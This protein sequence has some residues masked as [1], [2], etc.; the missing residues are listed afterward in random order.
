MSYAYLFKYIIIG[1]T[2]VGKS[3]LL[4]QFT[5]KRFQQVHDL[6]IGV[7][8][9]ARMITIDG[10]QIKLQIWD[11][12]GQESFRSITRSYYRGA[13]GALLVYDITRRDT[14][15]HLTSWL[16]DA[17]QHANSNMT[18]ML[19]GNKCD[20]EQRRAV[21]FEEGQQFANEHGL[22][23]LETSAKTAANVEEAFINTARKIYEKIQQGVFDVSNESYG[24]KV[25]MAAQ[26]TGGVNL[27]APAGGKQSSG[28][29]C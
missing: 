8:F 2:G 6:T 24:I 13:A 27:N 19:I 3:C 20:L 23:F 14:F 25:G 15:N 17:R 10:K 16:D 22:V 28:G 7:E 12:A 5:D 18:I 11:T 4:L 1:D 29:C 21:T 9:G 26:N